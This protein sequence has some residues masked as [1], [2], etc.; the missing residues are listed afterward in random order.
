MAQRQFQ[1]ITGIKINWANWGFGQDKG[2]NNGLN[3]LRQQLFAAQPGVDADAAQGVLRD[4]WGRARTNNDLRLWPNAAKPAKFRYLGDGVIQGL[5][6]NGQ[7]VGMAILKTEG[8]SG[9][10][11][12][13][14]ALQQAGVQAPQRIR[15]P[16]HLANYSAT[17]QVAPSAFRESPFHAGPGTRAARE[18]GQG[19]GRRGGVIG[20][21]RNVADRVLNNR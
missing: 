20:A 5:G 19:G 4:Y 11:G 6:R 13:H 10:A 3:T 18:A 8:E 14:Q 21:I 9:M 2:L 17:N 15:A 1:V 12:L 16:H 7:A